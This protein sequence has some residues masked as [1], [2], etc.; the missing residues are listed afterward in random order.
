MASADAALR[1]DEPDR[2]AFAHWPLSA[3]I[4]T[5]I[6]IGF[7]WLCW[8]AIH[9]SSLTRYALTGFAL[10]FV[11]AGILGIFWRLEVDIDLARRRVRIRRGFWPAP[12]TY[13][14]ALDEAD[15]IY[16]QLE[17]RGSDTGNAKRRVPCWFVS[18]KFP[19]EK[20]GTR[21]YASR[22]E[23]DAYGKWELFAR[24]LE[25][26]AVDATS[27][28]PERV[29]WRRLD[30]N[31]AA[32]VDAAGDRDGRPPPQPA[33]S[34]IAVLRTGAHTELQL[35][36]LGFNSGLV[37]IVLFGAA[38]IALGGGAVV[39]SLGL[40]DT[41]VQG[42]QWAVR[43]V[44]PVFVLAG[45]A[46]VWLGIWGSYRSV[47]VGV[48]RGA[49]YTENIVFGRRYGRK[50][51]PLAEIESITVG[52]DVRDRRQTGARV[53]VGGLTLGRK[54]YR[55]RESEVVVRSDER[56][57][58][59]GGSL[60]QADQVWLADACRYASIRGRLP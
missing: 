28:A 19:D 59:F 39:A 54:K 33:R 7:T 29:D 41:E 52:G 20:N 22:N 23:L 48:E 49:L 60:H 55:D 1:I 8:S 43:L 27:G 15:G 35:P 24:R 45:L 4:F 11:V 38:F 5:L 25:L 32:R 34:K 17:Y 10:I 31:V 53:R 9:D 21:I 46:I 6:S 44:P 37:F 16:L 51:V 58:R 56:I 47:I 36:R 2:L 3:V 14:R 42:S 12:K 18:L 57:L 13:E 50:S 40:I 26:D 30:E